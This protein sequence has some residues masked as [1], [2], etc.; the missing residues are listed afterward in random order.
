MALS[1]TGR[2]LVRLKAWGWGSFPPFQSFHSFE[3]LSSETPCA[4][5][6]SSLWDSPLLS[7]WGLSSTFL[8]GSRLLEFAHLNVCG[9]NG[10]SPVLINFLQ[11]L[12][13]LPR[14]RTRAQYCMLLHKATLLPP[15]SL[16]PFFLHTEIAAQFSLVLARRA[17]MGFLTMVVHER[18]LRGLLF[19]AN[20]QLLFVIE[21]GPWWPIHG[22][23]L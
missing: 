3:T 10:L 11:T 1:K 6:S 15:S 4:L 12:S 13:I 19:M 16:V 18:A 22:N 23:S 14:L 20:F 2:F 8:L 9:L 5:I 7:S 17:L 21:T